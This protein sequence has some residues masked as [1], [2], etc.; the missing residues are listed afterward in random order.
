[1][2]SEYS[3]FISYRHAPADIA[4]A[5]EIQ[6]RLERYPIPKAIRMKTGKEKIGKIFR[7][8]EELPIT[9]DLNDDISAALED[10]DYLIVICST[11][12]KESIWVER[13]I[14]YFLQNHSKKEVLTV[15]VNGE[16]YDV[17]P[18]ILLTD[19]VERTAP[20]GTTYE[21]KINYEP[22]S[23]DFRSGIKTARRTE[24]PRLAAAL[25]GCKY[26]ELVMRERQYRRRRLTA[27]LATT[28]TLAAIALAYL[29][30]SRA[31]IKKNYDLA[32]ENYKRA[33]ENRQRAEE[34]YQL[35]QENYEEAQ[36]NLEQSLMNQSA[37]LATEAD[38]LLDDGDRLRAIELMMEA[39]PSEENERPLSPRALQVLE[40]ALNAYSPPKTADLNNAMTEVAEFRMK[41]TGKD[42]F[43]TD[44]GKY[45]LGW[46]SYGIV[47]VWEIDTAE[48]IFELRSSDVEIAE[49]TGEGYLSNPGEIQ[50]LLPVTGE[51]L[52]V[53]SSAGIF[54]Y[55][56]V[57]RH[58]LWHYENEDYYWYFAD[59]SC[60]GDGNT[61]YLVKNEY[62]PYS[63]S[64]IPSTFYVKA[65]D[66]KTGNIKAE[67]ELTAGDEADFQIYA[68]AVSKNGEMFA[69]VAGK[70]L[71]EN[72][73]GRMFIFDMKIGAIR[74]VPVGERFM[75]VQAMRFYD[76]THVAVMG[77]P[78][79]SLTHAGGQVQ[80]FGIMTTV[81]NFR[82][83]VCAVDT[84]A[85]NVIWDNAFESPQINRLSGRKGIAA[86]TL[87][88]QKTVI[89]MYANKAVIFNAEDGQKDDE[90][91]FT[92]SIVRGG[93]TDDKTALVCYLD[94]GNLAS[95]NFDNKG[96]VT[97]I[98]YFSFENQGMDSA[99]RPDGDSVRFLVAAGPS[100]IRLYDSVYDEEFAAFD[101]AVLPSGSSIKDYDT[102]SGYLVLLDYNSVLYIMD[103]SGDGGLR[104]YVLN[105]EPYK[106]DY[107]G[108]DE[109]NGWVWL[110]DKSGSD[111]NVLRV[112]V[113]DGEMKPYDIEKD[114]FVQ[115]FMQGGGKISYLA[116]DTVTLI[117][118]AQDNK[119]IFSV[120]TGHIENR[121][122]VSPS[123]KSLVVSEKESYDSLSCQPFIIDTATGE[124]KALP[125][126]CTDTVRHACWNEDES[127]LALTDTS[128]VFLLNAK[129][130]LIRE[131]T[132]AGENIVSFTFYGDRL[133]VLYSGGL[134]TRYN[135][136]TGEL[137]GRTTINHYESDPFQDRAEW[138]FSDDTLCL[139]R[140]DIMRQ[141][142]SI[143]DLKTWEETD[144]TPYAYAYDAERDRLISM[145]YDR[146]TGEKPIGCYPR[147]TLEDLF[148]K[149]E[150]ALD[151]FT[152]TEEEKAAYGLM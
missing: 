1:M 26:D 48:L 10:A 131:L 20:D 25:L 134:L 71:F 89:C 80:L 95:H 38:K 14:R 68:S 148:R 37:H 133:V 76:E 30:W 11:S 127:L 125:A 56:F 36:Q 138:T 105:D 144:A 65:F 78:E 93:V 27:I 117:D 129:G 52:A 29:I 87:A 100:V 152:M 21:E 32:Q 67:S 139:N 75:E 53:K 59:I 99:P 66:A 126:A 137:T 97:E 41:G 42:F 118:P 47:Y 77:Y 111:S 12:T 104:T 22:L 57:N 109:E 58:E 86:G 140:K 43:V 116:D 46:D 63:L 82:I 130:E 6:K 106:F 96:N 35:A 2:S 115:F 40:R 141:L 31:E 70:G 143:I 94:N 54:V 60:S 3:A 19:T 62:S 103:L 15:L 72:D 4:V 108:K 49:D 45:L 55:D 9:S 114:R 74:E 124:K 24:I 135:A 79:Y 16:P 136:S 85:G 91:E 147:Y 39:L 107:I 120:E 44:D 69:F 73:Y 51:T 151:G 110:Q 149:A 61:V 119:E 5:A 98:T 112:S 81:E 146:N 88:E 142:L 13:E 33:E 113:K 90:I 8:K 145:G 132:Q 121:F 123:E 84:E 92:G 34:N 23:C 50:Y 128:S 28:G 83:N 122:F 18:E 102:V 101:D 17:I 7:D 64:P 150:E